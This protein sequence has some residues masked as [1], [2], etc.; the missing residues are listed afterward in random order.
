M[1]PPGRAD[2]KEAQGG[3][4]VPDEFKQ[5]GP[6]QGEPGAGPGGKSGGP[7][8]QGGAPPGMAGTLVGGSSVRTRFLSRNI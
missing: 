1:G 3:P 2:G 8:K 7:K 4:Y 6:P 5:N